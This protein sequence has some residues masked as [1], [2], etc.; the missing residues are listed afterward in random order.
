MIPPTFSLF[1]NNPYLKDVQAFYAKESPISPQDSITPPA[2]LTP[3]P[4]NHISTVYTP[5]PPQI[6]EIGKS[7]IKI[8]LK[9]HEEQIEDILNYLDE[10]SF[11]R[12][13]K[14]E[15]GRINDRMIIRRNGNELKTELKRIRTQIIKLQKKQ[16][17]QKDKI[18]FAHYRISNLEQIIEEIQARHQTDQEDL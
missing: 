10:L 17:G 6:F 9:H 18:A 4:Y 7:S 1:Y 16:L 2:I 12:I 8:D 13:E 5:T 14:M 15:E 3:S 11:H